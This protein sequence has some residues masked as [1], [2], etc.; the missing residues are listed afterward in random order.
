MMTIIENDR[1]CPALI[2]SPEELMVLFERFM[3]YWCEE[4]VHLTGLVSGSLDPES[5]EFT[6][7]WTGL[8]RGRLNLRFDPAFYPWLVRE[9][10]FKRLNFYTETELLKEITA[11]YGLYLIRYFSMADL[12][13]TGVLLP[14]RQAASELPDRDPDSQILLKVEQCPLEIKLWLETSK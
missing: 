7:Q 1:T 2:P 4:S 3:V 9:R 13:D 14:Q 10:G 11:L 8:V 12:A 5:S 6:V